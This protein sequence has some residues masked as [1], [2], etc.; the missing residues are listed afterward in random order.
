MKRKKQERPWN[1][2]R[3]GKSLL[4]SLANEHE[5]V[6][7][8]IAVTFLENG[9]E[10]CLRTAFA[11]YKTDHD[12]LDKLFNVHRGLL[13]S[14]ASK[15]WVARACGVIDQETYLALEAIRNLRN[16]F[17]HENFKISLSHPTVEEEIARLREYISPKWFGEKW[18]QTAPERFKQEGVLVNGSPH[19]YF[20]L[21]AMQVF[22]KLSLAEFDLRQRQ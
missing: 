3:E 9:L 15:G 8:L 6:Q 2:S 18:E 16:A 12:L 4:Q 13:S 5:R 10:Q 22:T 7:V 17:A 20:L 1:L 19:V 11:Q 14:L 21:A